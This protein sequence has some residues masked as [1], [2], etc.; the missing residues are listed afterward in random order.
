MTQA[1]EIGRHRA[2]PV[3][4]F[5]LQSRRPSKN[6][7]RSKDDQNN[8]NNQNNQNPWTDCLQQLFFL[9]SFVSTKQNDTIEGPR[10][11]CEP[12]KPSM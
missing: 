6:E 4:S 7:Q 11:K 12:S 5:A 9:A 10:G 2:Y 3:N 8:Q 1:L